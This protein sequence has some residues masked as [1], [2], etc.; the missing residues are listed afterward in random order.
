MQVKGSIKEN[1]NNTEE[2]SICRILKGSVVAIIITLVGLLILSL[3]LTYT[4][5]NE[6][7]SLPTIIIIT[8]ISIIIGSII[9]SKKISKRG[10]LNGGIVGFIYIAAIYILSSIITTG[11]RF[12]MYTLIMFIVAIVAGIIGGIIGVNI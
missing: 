3:I 6:N 9:S 8:A 12:N 4:S 1:K 11:F 10:M 5:A 7:V 2:K